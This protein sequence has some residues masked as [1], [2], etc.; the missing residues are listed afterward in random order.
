LVEKNKPAL[1]IKYFLDK[2]FAVFGLVLTSPIF[3]YVVIRLKLLGEDV[4]YLQKRM[5]YK[6]EEFYIYKFTTMPKGSEKFGLITTTN[7][8]RPFKFGKFL[9]KTK[10]N[11]LP[12]LINILKGDMSFIG[13]RP[14]I[15][16]QISEALS[17]AEIAEFYTMRPGITGAGSL[18]FHH[19]DIL[20]ACV[21]EPHQYYRDVIMPKKYELEKEYARNWTLLLDL[22]IFFMT[23]ISVIKP[24]SDAHPL[25][26]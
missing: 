9:R 17:E 19:E 24:G 12:Q 21:K 5:G 7:D 22:K 8:E 23:L 1:L 20:L 11:E 25:L 10:I 6:G 18:Y 2:L 14:L 15:R 16:T 4:F 13:P 3:L 26:D